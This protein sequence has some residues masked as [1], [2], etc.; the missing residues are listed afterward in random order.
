MLETALRYKKLGISIIPVSRDKKPMIEFA[1]REPLTEDEIKAFW[2]QNPTAN[3]AMKCDKFVVV[4]VD[5]HND[6]NG[7]ES[8]QPLLDEE[9]WKPTLS[10]TTASGGKQYFFLK[11]E[12]M[13][14]TQR[15]GFLKG[16]D[17]KAHENNYVVI[18]PSVT[19]KGQ[20]KWDNQ[21]PIITAPK[22]LIREIM[23]NRDNYTHYDFSGFTTSGSSKTAQLFETIVHGLGDSGGRND[24]LARFIGGLFLRNVDFDVVYQLAKQANFATSDPLE[25]KEFERTF[26]SM[27][28]KEMRRRNGIRSNGG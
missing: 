28:K 4:D 2:K 5:I 8:I 9:W 12:D 11:R 22:E 27:F 13:A 23:K 6:I 26:E 15:I 25:D 1:D 3:L 19:R 20:Y 16:V 7:Y 17:I 21:L 14:V 10:Q 24:A 18:P